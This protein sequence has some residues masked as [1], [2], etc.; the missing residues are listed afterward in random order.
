M[1][2]NWNMAEF[3]RSAAKTSDFPRDGLPQAVFAGRSNVGKSSVINRLLNRKNFARVGSAPGKT[4][5]I[6]YFCIDK[7]L[8]LVD[9]P[10]Y[11]YAKVS[12]QERDRWGRLI[13]SW[14]A[15]ADRMALGMLIV[16]ARHKPTADDC[17]MA[18]VFLSAE[19][20]FLVLANKLDKL[21]KSEI[22]GNLLRIRETLALPESAPVIP[23]SAEKGD[24]KSELVREILNCLEAQV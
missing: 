20:P 21:K 11:G 3:V 8:Y 9:L 1:T 17:T 4:T 14:F 6:N 15:D 18:Q 7:K 24:G 13:E 22:E 19:K 10:G 5:H 23:F 2:V 16:D 12:K